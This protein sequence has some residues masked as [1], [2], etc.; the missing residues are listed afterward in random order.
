[1]AAS[2]TDMG[3]AL[4]PSA[5][6]VSAVSPLSRSRRLFART[7]KSASNPDENAE[8]QWLLR[9]AAL[10]THST[11]MRATALVFPPKRL[12][13]RS[14]RGDLRGGY[15]GPARWNHGSPQASTDFC[16][17][18]G[19]KRTC[20]G[21]LMM[22]VR[23]GRPDVPRTRE[24]LPFLNRRHCQRWDLDDVPWPCARHSRP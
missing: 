8:P 17:I 11:V 19:T 6:L 22:S 20:R 7:A 23:E 5:R 2:T 3:G 21:D 24:T 13:S 10:W 16:N 1:M 18:I 4:W 12:F 14:L 15:P 9:R